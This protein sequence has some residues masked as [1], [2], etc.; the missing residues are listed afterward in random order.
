MSAILNHTEF[1]IEPKNKLHDL[2]TWLFFKYIFKAAIAVYLVGHTMDITLAVFDVGK[3]LAS[4]SSGVISHKTDVDVATLMEKMKEQMADMK[5]GELLALVM[6]TAFVG[7]LMK[8]LSVIITVALYGRMIEI[9]LYIS[10]APVP[11]ATFTNREWGQIGTHY[12]KGLFALAF[13]AF[14]IMVCVGIYGV[15]VTNIHTSDNIHS[16]LFGVTGYALLL[17]TAILKTGAHSRAIFNA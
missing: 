3:H 7:I 12:L 17:M 15:L 11:F 8:I 16:A 10:V 14:F 13:Q 4:S 1:C 6:E 5:N 2:D 9:Y